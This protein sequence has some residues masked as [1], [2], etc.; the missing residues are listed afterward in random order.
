MTTLRFSYRL[1]K[2]ANGFVA[3]CIESDAVGEGKT[4]AAA[5]ESLRMALKERMFRPESPP[6]SRSS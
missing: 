3:E 6:I 1:I 5:I 4:S 2:D